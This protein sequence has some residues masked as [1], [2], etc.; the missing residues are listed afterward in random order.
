M[1]VQWFHNKFN[2]NWFLLIA[3]HKNFFKNTSRLDI[4]QKTLDK[5][6]QMYCVEVLKNYEKHKREQ[7]TNFVN[8]LLR[9]FFNTNF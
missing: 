7:R 5:N 1:G 4:I 3:Y 9:E 2:L 6:T 8:A